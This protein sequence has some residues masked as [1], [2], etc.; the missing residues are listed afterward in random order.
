MFMS[1][2]D[3]IR[4]AAGARLP[5]VLVSLQLRGGEIV[6]DQYEIGG[7]L[8]FG[9]T[10]FVFS[11][12]RLHFGDEVAIKILRP[13]FLWDGELVQR[14]IQNAR[15][16]VKIKSEHVARVLDVG[17]LPDGAP[18]IV[19]E[20]LRGRELSGAL[21]GSGFL[22]IDTAI[23]YVL[24]AC[25]ALAFAHSV[26]VVHGD[27]QPANLFLEER[28]DHTE[29]I[30]VLDFGVA[31]VTLPA[32]TEGSDI[33]AGGATQALGSPVYMSPEQIRFTADIDGRADI[34]GLG[35]V[36]H[37][38]LTGEAAFDAPS[39]PELGAMILEREPA[40]LRSLR[41]SV[42]H[43]LEAIVARCLMKDRDQRFLDIAELAVAL[44][45]LASPRS[46]P[47]VQ[48]CCQLAGRPELADRATIDEVPSPVPE[49]TR[50]RAVATTSS[51]LFP[52]ALPV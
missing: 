14:F 39:L 50:E 25:E 49:L 20:K 30:K 1:V 37:E 13:E 27:I 23:D 15:A 6:D 5:D 8:G 43:E 38:L 10:G 18:F 35:C 42:P 11:A 7:L 47:S 16:A 40:R 51:S 41:S 4:R 29:W 3:V 24:Q 26:G 48:Y 36:L 44:R 32:E 12:R 31:N 45:P 19:M 21:A 2:H 46:Y 9:S 52:H 17:Q 33:P 28:P 22:P 34:W